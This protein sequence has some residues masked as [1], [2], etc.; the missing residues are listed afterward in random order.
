LSIKRYVSPATASSLL[1]R[2]PLAMVLLI[3]LLFSMVLPNT[4]I[5]AEGGGV[6]GIG[7]RRMTVRASL[8]QTHSDGTRRVIRY[9]D[10]SVHWVKMIT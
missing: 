6:L 9:K 2:A 7:D 1:A 3:A 10:L 5:A 8:H 4:A